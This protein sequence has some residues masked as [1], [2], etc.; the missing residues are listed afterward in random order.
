MKRFF[1]LLLALL[2]VVGCVG[3]NNSGSSENSGSAE[4]SNSAGSSEATGSEV[5]Y[6]DT[7]IF[8]QPADAPSLDPQV[9]KQLRA[10]TVL[11]NMFETLVTTD[12]NYEVVPCLAESWEWVSDTRVEFTL[13]KDVK[14]HNGETMTAEDVRYSLQRALDS[15]YVGYYFTFI[16]SVEIVSDD[17]VAVNLKTPYGAAMVTLAAPPASIVCKSVASGDEEGFTNNPV[18]TGPYKFVEWKQSES[19]KLEAFDEYWGG[20]APTKY[21]VMKV[22]PESTQRAIQLETGEIDLAYEFAPSEIAK[23]EDSD[24]LTYYTCES[25]KAVIFDVNQRK[26]AGEPLADARVRQAIVCAIDKQ[27]IVDKLLYGH[28]APAANLSTPVVFGF[29]DSIVANK[30]DPEKAKALLSEAGFPDGFELNIWTYT[31]Q[32]YLEVATVVQSM[33]KEVGITATIETMEYSTM[34][35]RISGG[36]DYDICLDYFNSTTGDCGHTLYGQ[37]ASTAGD[38]S[39]WCRLSDPAVD[40]LIAIVRENNDDAVRSEA[41]SKL[42]KYVDEVVPHFGMYYENVLVGARKDV[43]NFQVRRDGYHILR[44]VVVIDG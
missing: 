24:E 13:R 6:K 8:A 33:L 30:Y 27:M 34:S 20:A 4:S 5:K 11:T 18:G 16:D 2:L 7:L 42:W 23:L 26:D 1:A 17:V 12:E 3:C 9:G 15:S 19:I 35:A 36:E 21:V 32:I 40:E 28:G 31:E 10:C 41:A 44:N 38:N 43:Q 29:D 22:V 25:T 39:N 37:L 14:F